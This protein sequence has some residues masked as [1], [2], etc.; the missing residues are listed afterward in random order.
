[1]II[2][3]LLLLGK[4]G[5]EAESFANLIKIK[6]LSIYGIEFNRFLTVERIYGSI[7]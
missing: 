7:F 1:M 6:I 4:D 5:I 3:I 2:K